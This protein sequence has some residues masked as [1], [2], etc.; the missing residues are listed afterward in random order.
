MGGS[1]GQGTKAGLGVAQHPEHFTPDIGLQ[2]INRED[3]AA[4]FREALPQPG[5]IR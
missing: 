1:V 2:P 5:R 4:L 3:D